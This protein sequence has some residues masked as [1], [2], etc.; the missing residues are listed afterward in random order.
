MDFALK[1][2]TCRSLP[3]KVCLAKTRNMI[4]DK[5]LSHFLF[6]CLSGALLHG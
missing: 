3:L 2:A 6:E 5:R 1:E 4:I